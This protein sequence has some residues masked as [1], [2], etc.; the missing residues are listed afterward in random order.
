MNKNF[1]LKIF[2]EN[3][4]PAE[5]RAYEGYGEI[6]ANTDNQEVIKILSD[7]KKDEERHINLCKRA[8]EILSK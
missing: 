4:L 3:F 5:E 8:I 1:L 7:I 6:I 2:T